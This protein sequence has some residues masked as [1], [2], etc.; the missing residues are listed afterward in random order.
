MI[1]LSIV[2]IHLSTITCIQAVMTTHKIC[3]TSGFTGCECMFV[4]GCNWGGKPN[5]D[6]TKNPHLDGF[7]PANIE[8]FAYEKS[9]GVKN[10]GW[11]CEGGTVAIL[12][13][14]DARIPLYSAT[15]IE[16]NQAGQKVDRSKAS[17]HASTDPLLEVEFQQTGE[18]YAG[19]SKHTFCY[20]DQSSGIDLNWDGGACT[21]S[22]GPIDRGHMVSAG[23]ARADAARVQNTFAYTN[24]VPQFSVFNRG[25]WRKAEDSE[26]VKTW[27]DECHKAA[28]TKGQDARIYVVVGAIPS[29]PNTRFFGR[30]GFSNFESATYRIVV[31]HTMWTAACCILEDN[32]VLRVMAFSRENIPVKDKVDL[33]TTPQH[34]FK[35]LFPTL[36]T[37]VDLF[38]QKPGCMTG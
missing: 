30:D 12:Y 23:Y 26:L 13:D 21:S 29:T 25:E 22:P 31:P 16:G 34:M 6:S 38:P 11:I 20:R 15:V 9:S 27:G 37:L 1:V 4:G 8:Q 36:K 7:A 2:I 10:L 32:T 17:F 35:T 28:G 14:C 33:Y 5:V 3:K 18:D 24:M 19:S